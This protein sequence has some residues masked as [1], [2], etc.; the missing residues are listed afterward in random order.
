MSHSQARSPQQALAIFVGHT[1]CRWLRCLRAGFR[2]CF[3]AL[4]DG[5]TWLTCDP[6]KD[7]I[8]LRVLPVPPDFDLSGHY[9]GQG[10][11]V[12][13]G[14]ARSD[15]PRRLP[16]LVPLTCV[17]VAKRLLGVQAPWV[18]SPWQLCKR[19][20]SPLHGFVEIPRARPP[21]ELPGADSKLDSERV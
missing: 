4:R 14:L 11:M 13:R 16:A 17:T 12:L 7:R 9:A 8:E 18:L 2:H 10:H 15:L 1:D 5:N 20:R 3:V 6:L 19:L 21:V